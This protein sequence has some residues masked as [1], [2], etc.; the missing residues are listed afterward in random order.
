MVGWSLPMERFR[1]LEKLGEGGM[2]EIYR[3][4]QTA[5]G[6]E[7]A[8][9]MLLAADF[10]EEKHLVRF[11]REAKL[12]SG[13]SHPHI[14]RVF[15]SGMLEGKPYFTMELIQG[16]DLQSVIET[17]GPMSF[18]RALELMAQLTD[19]V[20]LLHQHEIAHRDLKPKNLVLDRRD[21]KDHVVLIDFGLARAA[22]GTLVTRAGELIGTFPYMPPE[23]FR[24]EEAGPPQD[25]WA[26]AL[27]TG[28]LVEGRR[29]I[30][31]QSPATIMKQILALDRAWLAERL[32]GRPSWFV[33]LLADCLANDP[34]RRPTARDLHH[35]IRALLPRAWAE[36]GPGG[37]RVAVRA[38]GEAPAPSGAEDMTD[39]ARDPAVPPPP[40]TH[41]DPH[42]RTETRRTERRWTRPLVTGVTAA[43]LLAASLAAFRP[44]GT[45]RRVPTA[46]LYLEPAFAGLDETILA[47]RGPLPAGA[48]LKIE[49]GAGPDSRLEITRTDSGGFLVRG[50]PP[51]TRCVLST[52]GADGQRIGEDIE[53]TT[54]VR[55]EV[56]WA[57]VL[58]GD[59]MAQLAVLR[60]PVVLEVELR[61][62]QSAEWSRV[63]TI[64]PG[65]PAAPAT[66]NGLRPS[67]T[68]W[69]RAHPAGE[70]GGLGPLRF[71]T[72]NEAH[73]RSIR[74][75]GQQVA[76]ADDQA[77]D[78][79]LEILLS[80]EAPDPR[81]GPHLSRYLE[82]RKTLPRTILE[83]IVRL[84]TDIQSAD[85]ARSLG[86]RVPEMDPYLRARTCLAM[87]RAGLP[88]AGPLA[89]AALA[90]ERNHDIA[91]FLISSLFISGMRLDPSHF[92]ILSQ[93]PCINTGGL[94]AKLLSRAD[95]ARAPE[96][97]HQWLVEGEVA[98]HGI[99]TEGTLGLCGL[100]EP[101]WRRIFA[102]HARPELAGPLAAVAS[103]RHGPEVCGEL[104]TLLGPGCGPVSG[105][106]PC[107]SAIELPG[108]SGA[109]AVLEITAAAGLPAARA[110]LERLLEDPDP[111]RVE[112]AAWA[113]A[114]GNCRESIPAL[115]DVTDSGK[116]AVGVVLWALARLGA[117]GA[118][119]RVLERLA[120]PEAADPAEVA[121]LGLAA[122]CAEILALREARPLLEA[123]RDRKYA[124]GAFLRHS[125]RRAL[126]SV[127]RD[128][129]DRSELMLPQMPALRLDVDLLPGESL[130]VIAMPF[131]PGRR[132][133]GIDG[134]GSR[135]LDVGAVM[136]SVHTWT[137]L[138]G[139]RLLAT[140]DCHGR[141]VIARMLPPRDEPTRRCYQRIDHER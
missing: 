138:A 71:E 123:I 16:R 134:P 32:S 107:P 21:G 58:P 96:L 76:S 49:S 67:T 83:S 130:T 1:I 117:E 110:A 22:S 87:A 131:L 114:Q 126:E 36:S 12:L 39:T 3:A 34:A 6:R 72:R 135:D 62:R 141:V 13:F 30:D 122:W 5:L 125:V 89:H 52:R 79:P 29:L 54:P 25:V 23:I 91:S 15:E 78:V 37:P 64:T 14:V 82:S 108:N 105:G 133:D 127:A 60:P 26:L 95:P 53:V 93:V 70:W 51:A 28:E 104:R 55:H 40:G 9:K 4:R 84:A 94:L 33:D 68:Y 109:P 128:R 119:P 10:A 132:E 8:L 100:N 97:F 41:H 120:H 101:E 31:R 103:V 42:D 115:I 59:N 113:L 73:G 99:V 124:Q 63:G 121:R 45:E 137:H 98:R 27:I 140:P 136:G 18:P 2:G 85:L 112:A 69:V 77:D 35:R 75:F 139:T 106:T 19:A 43:L 80:S 66:L 90:G 20:A 44:G 86:R 88:E 46:R 116:D 102:K 81:M 74:I 11:H 24:D 38:S 56:A 61:S 111:A 47:P 129:H 17:E 7:V 48:I 92:D 65:A 57:A 118:A 50:L